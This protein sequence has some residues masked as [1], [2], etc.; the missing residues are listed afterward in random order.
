MIRGSF[1]SIRCF[2]SSSGLLASKSYKLLVVGGGAGG[3]SIASKFASK[4]GRGHVGIIEPKNEHYYQPLWTL[5]GG[6]QCK[7][8]DSGKPMSTVLPKK[9]DWIQQK[10]MN[11]K[12]EENKV[13]IE[14]GTEIEYEYLV[15]AMGIQLNYNKIKGLEDALQTPGVG[16]NYHSA[17]VKNTWKSIC[18][19]K[20]GNALFTFP[21]TPIKC[22]GAPQKIMYLAE[23]EF[24]KRG[25][26]EKANVSYHTSLPVL[27]GVKKYADSLWE[28]V[29]ERGI[30]VN[31]RSN[32]IELKPDSREA[33]FQNMD[34]PEDLKTLP[35]EMIHV[36]PPMSAPD[37]LS[38]CKTL[39][40]TTGYLNVD[41]ETLQHLT[42]PNIFGVGDC[43]NVPTSKTA[44]AVAAEVGVVRRNL[45]SVMQ[46]QNSRAVYDGY[47]S[48]P[49]VIGPGECILAEFDFNAPPQPLE[50]FPI[51]QAKPR[52]LIYYMKKHMM[53]QVYWTMLKGY[54]EGPKYVRK[55][56]HLGLSR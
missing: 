34:A 18:D 36:T 7:L 10:A 22:A 33:V 2:S 45:W 31:L 12:P 5:V 27:F 51:N 49:L 8:E 29:N 55:L 9:A 19:F 41:K 16:S 54:W 26:R 50:T 47:T 21:S 11:F 52:K 6:G 39:V 42:Y 46:G 44:A 48:C 53:P 35:Y 30:N 3:C 24:K 15:V 56:L 1:S 40:D 20:S 25:I 37:V 43:T 17:Y 13:V 14:D 32:L 28:V 23:R 4:L 38:G